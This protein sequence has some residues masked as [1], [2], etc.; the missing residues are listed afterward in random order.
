MMN[1]KQN[2]GKITLGMIKGKNIILKYCTNLINHWL[3]IISDELFSNIFVFS[4]LY[5]ENKVFISKQIII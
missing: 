5:M 3:S 1:S 2:T 4:I